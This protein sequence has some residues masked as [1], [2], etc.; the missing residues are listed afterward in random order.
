MTVI[1]RIVFG[2]RQLARL[3][4]AVSGACGVLKSAD[5]SASTFVLYSH[6]LPYRLSK[7]LWN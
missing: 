5:C 6:L 2:C 3:P 1:R 4:D 7:L